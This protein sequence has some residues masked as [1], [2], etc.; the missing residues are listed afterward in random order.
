MGVFDWGESKDARDQ[1]YS[2]DQPHEAKFS[3]EMIGS[4][5]GFEAMHLWENEQRKEGKPVEHG[6]AKELLCAA[7][8]YEVDRLAESKGLDWLDREKAK[9][10]AK[11]QAKSLYDQQ[12]Q[13]QSNYDP[14]NS[15]LHDDLNY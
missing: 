8:G 12:Y 9:H 10:H 14:N 3:H 4:A 7:A 13:D 11:E 1:V 6:V 5:A 2:D 15:Q